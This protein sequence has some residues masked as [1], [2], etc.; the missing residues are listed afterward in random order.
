MCGIYIYI[1]SPYIHLKL[2]FLNKGI[3]GNVRGRGMCRFDYKV[4]YVLYGSFEE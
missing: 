3:I 4:L 2:S 1:I